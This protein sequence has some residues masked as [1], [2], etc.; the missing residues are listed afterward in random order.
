M[1]HVFHLPN[2]LIGLKMEGKYWSL[3]YSPPGNVRGKYTKNVAVNTTCSEFKLVPTT[4]T[5][6]KACGKNSY[7]FA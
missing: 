6:S 1:P 5:K 7:I 3:G 2:L 4:T